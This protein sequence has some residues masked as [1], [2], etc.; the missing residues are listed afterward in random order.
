MKYYYIKTQKELDNLVSEIKK[1]KIVVL[2][3]E[4]T[5]RVTYYP[6]LSLIQVGVIGKKKELFLID[7]LDGLNLKGFL[8]LISSKRILKILHSAKQDLQIFYK[9]SG[10]WPKNVADTQIMANLANFKFNSGYSYLVEKIC[11]VE[12][13]KAEQ[14]S[15]WQKRPLSQSQ[16]DYALLD[17]EYLYDVYLALH[18]RLEDLGRISWL[19]DE[20]ENVIKDYLIV[21][22]SN[23]F[24]KFSFRGR[25]FRESEILKKLI[26]HREKCARKADVPRRHFLRDEHLD[27]MVR[28]SKMPRKLDDKYQKEFEKILKSRIRERKKDKPILD[29]KEISSKK[30]KHHKAKR[31]ISRKANEMDIAANILLN[32]NQLKDLLEKNQKFK[33]IVFGWRYK[34]FGREL[35]EIINN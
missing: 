7:A 17:V 8:K 13:D 24:K 31:L 28:L 25:S 33:A 11:G 14:N 3:T 26:L 9:A 6:I 1:S 12:L 20:M 34:I 23:L 2:D 5:R 16:I 10:S 35:R 21:D 32:A 29:F 15:D 19:G 22:D 30:S 4:F 18:Q 27:K